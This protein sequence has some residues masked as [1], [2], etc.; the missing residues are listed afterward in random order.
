MDIS[1]EGRRRVPR[2]GLSF[3]GEQQS[4]SPVEMVK[5]FKSPM[6]MDGLGLARYSMA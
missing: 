1:G 4:F 3:F 5:R 6:M 2:L